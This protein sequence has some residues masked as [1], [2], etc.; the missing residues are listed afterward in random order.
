M[1]IRFLI[2]Q[3][4]EINRRDFMK[5]A[6]GGLAGATVGGYFAGDKELSQPTTPTKSEPKPNVK[7]PEVQRDRDKDWIYN[8]VSDPMTGESKGGR[9]WVMSDDGQARL[10]VLFGGSKQLIVI[11]VKN[12][13]INFTID[14]AGGRIKVGGKVI[15]VHIDRPTSGAYDW[16]GIWENWHPGLTKRLFAGGEIKVEVPI[17][18]EGNKIYTWHVSPFNPKDPWG[19]KASKKTPSEEPIEE[20]SDEA[21]ARIVELS[22]K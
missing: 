8:G 1:D 6:G 22:K 13:I 15:P 14:G 9:A 7:Q 20:A 16:G 10:E 3:L 21:I 19:I 17:Y 11:E 12:Q 18:R 4:D 5:A 2:E